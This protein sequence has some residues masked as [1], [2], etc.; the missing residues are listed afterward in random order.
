[1]IPTLT[2]TRNGSHAVFTSTQLTKDIAFTPNGLIT[3]DTRRSTI[4]CTYDK[5]FI[6][7]NKNTDPI[8]GNAV[9]ADWIEAHSHEIAGTLTFSVKA[10]YG[11]MFDYHAIRFAVQ[12][13]LE[14]EN[15]NV[16]AFCI[17]LEGRM[18]V[19]GRSSSNI[20]SSATAVFAKLFSGTG[21]TTDYG[22]AK[23]HANTE[24][25]LSATFVLIPK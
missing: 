10:G 3:E 16:L 8:V 17:T 19:E 1:M 21:V 12:R 7:T 6:V 14:Q 13:F 2:D 4:T 15:L 20:I 11:A 24:P 18:G 23:G 22:D 5:G 9:D 25:L